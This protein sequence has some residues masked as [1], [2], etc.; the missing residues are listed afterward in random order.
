MDKNGAILSVSPSL[1][2]HPPF[3]DLPIFGVTLETAIQRSLLGTDG[4]ELPTVF[5]ECIS[6]LEGHC[7]YPMYI[8][9]VIIYLNILLAWRM[10]TWACC[11]ASDRM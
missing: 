2:L 5:R 11:E 6:Y 4:I 8:L 9:L 3:S 7:K 1:L 10:Q